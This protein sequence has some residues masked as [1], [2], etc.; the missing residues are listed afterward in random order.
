MRTRKLRIRI[1]DERGTL[2]SPPHAST[3]VLHVEEAISPLETF[4][5]K[6]FSKMCSTRSG[7]IP[8]ACVT[9]T[10]ENS[11]GFVEKGNLHDSSLRSFLLNRL[12]RIFQEIAHDQNE[13][14]AVEILHRAAETVRIER[15]GD[16]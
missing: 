7:E 3:D 6:P 14:L 1:R 5:E 9:D 16:V 13:S 10:H 11:S 2:T 12:H 15:E 4:V 8:S